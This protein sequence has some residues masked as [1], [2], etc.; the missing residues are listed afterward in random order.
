MRRLFFIS[1]SNLHF[2]KL[3]NHLVCISRMHR[4]Q[5]DFEIAEHRPHWLGNDQRSYVLPKDTSNAMNELLMFSRRMNN[6][7]IISGNI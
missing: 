2:L 5:T 3:S 4:D 1:K 7:K 6:G